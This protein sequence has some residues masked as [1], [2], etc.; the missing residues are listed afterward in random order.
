MSIK[1][2]LRQLAG[3]VQQLLG[4]VKD[5][6]SNIRLLAATWYALVDSDEDVRPRLDGGETGGH[7][8]RW[9]I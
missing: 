8:A 4:L 5:A 2:H 6:R 9:C 1:R 3:L 7:G